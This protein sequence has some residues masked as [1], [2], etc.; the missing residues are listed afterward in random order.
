MPEELVL[1]VNP[2]AGAGRAARLLPG[3]LTA[4]RAHGFEP[5][6]RRTERARHA[7]E[8]VR[9][10]LESGAPGVGRGPAATEP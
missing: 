4:L 10:A 5:D 7:T 3:L 9:E 6:I 8:L 2:R 1:I